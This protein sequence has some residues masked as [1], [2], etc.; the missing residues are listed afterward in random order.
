[1]P[2]RVLVV[3]DE[4]DNATLLRLILEAAG[5]SVEVAGDLGTARAVLARGPSPDLLL[6]D[7]ILPDGD[8]LEFC[9]GLKAERPDLPVIVLTAWD[10]ARIR[11]EALEGCADLFMTKPFDLQ[12][13]E[14]AVKR[15]LYGDHDSTAA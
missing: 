3:E 6:L 10:Q 11:E 2:Q 9:R 5:Y 8:G 4:P 13:L 7:L 14:T 15:L 1:M 12:E